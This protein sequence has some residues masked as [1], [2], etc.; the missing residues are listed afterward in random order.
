M[1]MMMMTATRVCWISVSSKMFQILSSSVQSGCP[2][3]VVA[4]SHLP[5]RRGSQ[6]L[7]MMTSALTR[8][9]GQKRDTY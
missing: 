4:S 1:M 8:A 3:A 7:L 5:V 2:S 9:K 6:L